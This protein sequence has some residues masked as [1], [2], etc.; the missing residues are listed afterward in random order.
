MQQDL[1]FR[2]QNPKDT[3]HATCA[4]LV[5]EINRRYGLL[6]KEEVKLYMENRWTK[7]RYEDISYD[8]TFNDNVD[9]DILDA[10]NVC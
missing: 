6:R 9:F 7:D 10:K 3:V 8:E 4:S 1:L 5:Q 2:K